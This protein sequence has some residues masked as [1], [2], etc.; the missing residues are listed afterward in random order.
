MLVVD[1]R[2]DPGA[3]APGANRAQVQAEL[4]KHHFHPSGV[5][6]STAMPAPVEV[7]VA[8]ATGFEV[9]HLPSVP[10][11]TMTPGPAALLKLLTKRVWGID[12]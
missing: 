8:P 5:L 9:P 1:R 7:E 12:T 11:V 2:D 6:E 3:Y 4:E 10:V